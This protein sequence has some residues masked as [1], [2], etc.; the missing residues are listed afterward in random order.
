[1]KKRR[2]KKIQ[3]YSSDEIKKREERDRK[4]RKKHEKDK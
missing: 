3:R 2:D 4:Q 1:M